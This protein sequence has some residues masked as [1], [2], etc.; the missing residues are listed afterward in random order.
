MV[1]LVTKPVERYGLSYDPLALERIFQ[2]ASGHPYFTQVICHEL[3]AYHNDTERNYITTTCVDAVLD[4]IIERGEAHFKY[5]WAESSMEQRLLLVAL[6]ELLETMD[7]ATLDDIAGVLEKRGRAVETTDL[8]EAA[9]KLEARDILLRSG[10][11][12]N[13][14]RFRVDLIRRWIYATR[15]AYEK[16]H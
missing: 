4:R 15:P 16:I 6:A 5:I 12:S 3:V 8:N 11:R 9:G 2:V 14:Y 1:Q 7:N 13:L 10:P